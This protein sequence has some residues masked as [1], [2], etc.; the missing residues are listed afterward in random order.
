MF[1]VASPMCAAFSPIQG[2][3]EIPVLVRNTEIAAPFP[4]MCAEC[5]LAVFRGDK[6]LVHFDSRTSADM[7]HIVDKVSASC[8]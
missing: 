1:L 7:Q 4:A 6:V 5:T 3:A 2:L 8:A